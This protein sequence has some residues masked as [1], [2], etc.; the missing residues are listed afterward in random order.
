MGFWRPHQTRQTVLLCRRG[1]EEDTAYGNAAIENC[2][3]SSRADRRLQRFTRIAD[4]GATP[5][6][7]QTEHPYSWQPPRSRSQ[8][9][10]TTDGIA[11]AK[12][13]ST[14]T[15]LASGLSPV[16]PTGATIPIALNATF[17]PNNPFNW[18]QDL[19]RLDY[20]LNDK[21]SLYG[22]YLHDNF[23]LVD[24]FGTFVDAGVLPTTPTHRLR[25]GYGIQI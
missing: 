7:G 17:Q 6:A 15:A 10:P 14:M 4:S 12:N 8:H 1:M 2:S 19:V 13:Y 9:A 23:D 11:V 3:H 22:R 25:P 24:G 5:R 18:R 20:R 21:H 16:I